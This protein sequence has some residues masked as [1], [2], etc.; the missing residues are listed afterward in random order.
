M[1]FFLTGK[2]VLDLGT[3]SVVL[4]IA[5]RALGAREAHGVDD[6][7]DAIRAARENL[8]LN[9]TIDHVTF[10][11][12]DLR[13][14]APSS[15]DVITANLTGSLLARAAGLIASH[16]APRGVLIASGVT[17]GERDTVVAAFHAV[18][19]RHETADD[20]WVGLIFE[21]PPVKIK[22]TR[23]VTLFVTGWPKL[24]LFW[25]ISQTVQCGKSANRPL[26]VRYYLVVTPCAKRFAHG[27]AIFIRYCCSIPSNLRP[28]L[29]RF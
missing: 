27:V 1:A 15:A 14:L 26:C 13:S 6:D 16:L 9:P 17:A 23:P 12:S 4:A 10:D 8:A 29:R 18:A 3:G 24:G 20:G 5:A 28:L 2:R 19:L 25:K 21:R 11:V 7:P 22:I